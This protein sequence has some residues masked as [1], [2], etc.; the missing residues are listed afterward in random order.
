MLTDTHCHIDF[1]IFDKDRDEILKRCQAEDIHRIV[2][3]SVKSSTWS[4]TLKLCNEHSMLI[5]A[6]GLHPFF[7]ADHSESDL[8]LLESFCKKGELRAIGE[9]G[10]DFL[11]KQLDKSQQLLYFQAQLLLAQKYSLPVLIHARKSHQDVIHLLKKHVPLKGIIHAFNGSDIQAK[12]Y[13][14]LGFA[15]GFGGAF[16]NPGAKHLRYLV[17]SLPLSA[18]VLETDAPDMLPFFAKNT[19]NSPGKKGNPQRNSPENMTGIFEQ[20]VSLRTEQTIKIE[21]QLENNYHQLFASS[22]CNFK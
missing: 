7:L 17:S 20:F 3:P 8:L 16:T 2:V 21:Q 13:M 18:M 19:N 15:L 6:L 9:I 14:D 5:P 12:Q 22:V 11:I 10:L 4:T 1:K